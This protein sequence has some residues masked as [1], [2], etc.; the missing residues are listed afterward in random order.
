MFQKVPENFDIYD[1]I[2]VG[3]GP[4]NLSLAIQATESADSRTDRWLILEKEQEVRWHPGMILPGSR[5]DT[6]FV[7][8]LVSLKDPTS[9]FSFL[10]Y[11]ADQGRIED[12]LNCGNTSPYRADFDRYIQWVAEKLGDRIATSTEVVS[13]DIE[14]GGDYC[15]TVVTTT[16]DSKIYRARNIVVGVGFKPRAICGL[17]LTHPRVIHSSE[18]L[19][20]TGPSRWRG[21]VS[22][23]IA[24]P[25]SH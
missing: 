3:A 12:F 20:K 7:K 14:D 10:N 17:D 25:S 18:F 15:V 11:L 8:D 13:I 16:G 5:L 4:A 9:R 22:R 2:A 6:H 1:F 24:Q 21:S 19:E 23:R